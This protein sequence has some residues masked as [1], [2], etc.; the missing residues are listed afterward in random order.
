MTRQP[1]RDP[2]TPSDIPGFCIHLA[3]GGSANVYT[4]WK[5]YR[6]FVLPVDDATKVTWVRFIKKK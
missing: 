6:Y 4:T 3:V 5:S 2:H 1:H